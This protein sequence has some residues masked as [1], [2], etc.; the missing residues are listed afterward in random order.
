MARKIHSIQIDTISVVTRSHNLTTWNRFPKYKEGEVWKVQ[1]EGKLFEWWSHAMCLMPMETYP[2]TAWR[3]QF[4]PDDLWDSFKKWGADN[5]D[6]IEQVYQKVKKDGA[7]NSASLGERK[8]KSDGWWDWK[9]EKRALEYLFYTGRLMVPYR[10][11]F[12]KHYDL[13]DRVLPAGIDSEPL[14][15]D[16]AAEFVVMTTLAS[17][18]LGSQEDV[19][20]YMGRMPSRVFWKNK[21]AAVE[22]YLEEF[23]RDGVIEEVSI[24]TLKD[25]YF[26]LKKNFRRLSKASN[27]DDY[28]APV[29]FLSPFDNIIRERHYPK[30]IWDFEYALECYTP[31]DKRKYG[32][33]A[34]PL[35]DGT[36]LVGRVDAKAHRKEG[37]L[38]LKSLYLESDFWKT[39]DGIIRLVEGLKDFADFHGAEQLKIEKVR[40]K[41]AKSPIL[42][43]I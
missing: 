25:R 11:G 19:R 2:F 38:E 12:Q 3:K 16:E 8:A 9:A 10:K 15:D 43:Q 39:D 6:T 34:L 23:V 21:A 30:K 17:L 5:K 35:L 32:Y 29:K 31:A 18:G 42:N 28:N 33:F 22:E 40:P 41:E 24:P 4:Y 36:N 27:Q 1:K 13:T 20:T 7:V 37:V 14:S 26:V